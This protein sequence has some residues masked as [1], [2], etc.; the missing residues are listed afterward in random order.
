MPRRSGAGLLAL[1]LALASLVAATPAGAQPAPRTLDLFVHPGGGGGWSSHTVDGVAAGASVPALTSV[2]AD[3]VL[4]EQS[5]SG[6]LVVAD[7]SLFDPF[8]ATDLTQ[9]DAAPQPAGTPAALSR[10]G[11]VWLFY[12]TT[13]GDLEAAVRAPDDGAWTF[14]DVTVATAAPPLAGPP[15]AL[16]SPSGPEAFAVVAGGTVEEFAAPRDAGATPWT[17]TALTVEG[18]PSLSGSLAAFDAPLAG[19][20]TVVLGASVGHDLVE[21][22][23]ESVTPP[24]TVGAWRC[25]D[26]SEAGLPAVSGPIAAI[27]GAQPYATYPS[28]GNTEAVTLTTGYPGGVRVEDLT[29]VDDLW[30]TSPLAPTVVQAPGGFEVAQPSSEGDLQLVQLSR[31]PHLADLTFQPQTARRVASAVASTLVG[32]ATVL[33]ASDGG[34]ISTSPLRTRIAL[35]AAS[36][37]QDHGDYQTVPAGSDCNRFTAWWGRGSTS[38]CPAGTSSEA[39]CSDFASYIWARAGVPVNGITGWAASFI[40]WGQLHHRVQMGRRFHPAVGDAIVWGQRSPLYG[41]HV[42]IIVWAQGSSIDVVSGNSGGDLPGYGVGV[43]RWGAF[44]G[45]SSTVLGYHVLGVVAP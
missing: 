33:V 41:Q 14:T 26:L 7:G 42:G 15:V 8:T 13:S 18:C 37:D 35:L 34:P 9:A 28:W 31:S 10:A 38:G 32:S 22:S 44:D 11:A 12:E 19:A 45:P 29:S 39:W 25:S 2:G 23:D 36:F 1:A 21:L 24:R 20:A 27:G 30:P 43:W 3:L 40:T 17:A 4:A 6:D 16:E 5:T